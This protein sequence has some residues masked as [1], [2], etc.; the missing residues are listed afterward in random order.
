MLAFLNL[1]SNIFSVVSRKIDPI[2]EVAQSGLN[3]ILSTVGRKINGGEGSQI[4]SD[5]NIEL[6]KTIL[7]PLSTLGSALQKKVNPKD[8]IN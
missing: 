4:Q 1:F 6:P 5:I 2:D 7:N 3:T 8:E